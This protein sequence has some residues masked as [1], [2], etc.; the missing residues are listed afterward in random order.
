MIKRDKKE[1]IRLRAPAA[2]FAC[3]ANYPSQEC[4]ISPAARTTRTPAPGTKGGLFCICV[5]S[6]NLT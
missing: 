5:E 2:L 1:L 3:G 6:R 4:A